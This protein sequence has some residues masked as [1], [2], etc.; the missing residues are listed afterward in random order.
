MLGQDTAVNGNG[1]V[2]RRDAGQDIADTY[3]RRGHRVGRGG[4][5]VERYR[6]DGAEAEQCRRRD[7][8]Q[9]A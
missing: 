9:S 1:Q 3:R 5:R 7:G 4:G 6:G 2:E 8:D